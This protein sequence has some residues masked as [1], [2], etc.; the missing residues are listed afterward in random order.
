MK[1]LN[2]K[3]FAITA[4]IYSI[5][6]LFVLILSSFLQILIG[7]NKRTDALLTSTYDNISYD[8]IVVEF[9][10]DG[11][12]YEGIIKNGRVMDRIKYSA[13]EDEETTDIYVT[14]KRSIYIFSYQSNGCISI[15]PKNTIIINSN[16]KTDGDSDKLYYYVVTEEDD[17]NS[18]DTSKYKELSCY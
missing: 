14:E 6:L 2:N 7:R 11:T 15:L 10:S 9:E 8:L 3:G 16:I 1:K 17:E 13:K 5:M 4:I 18:Q 12:V